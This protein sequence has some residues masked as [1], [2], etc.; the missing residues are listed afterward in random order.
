MRG[1]ALRGD[2]E[3]LHLQMQLKGPVVR[4]FLFV[5]GANQPHSGRRATAS[6]A[7]RACASTGRR[8]VYQV[9][10]PWNYQET[11]PRTGAAVLSRR[12]ADLQQTDSH[13]TGLPAVRA[14]HARGTLGRGS[15]DTGV[16]VVASSSASSKPSFTGNVRRA[17]R[18]RP[19]PRPHSAERLTFWRPA[20]ASVPSTST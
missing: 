2:A 7:A 12:V 8:R 9:P 19:C 17:S 15:E 5:V 10:G 4:A 20:R 13:P 18:R 14:V 1:D 6:R 11:S 3:L 16:A